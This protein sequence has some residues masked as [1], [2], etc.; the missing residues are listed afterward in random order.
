MRQLYFAVG[1]LFFAL[2]VIGAFLPVMPTT[3]FML[4]ALWAFAKSSPRFHDWLYRHPFFGP[5]LQQWQRHRVI[6]RTAKIMSI[7]MMSASL[8]YLVFFSGQPY[9][10]SAIV[11]AVMLYAAW[12]ILTKPSAIPEVADGS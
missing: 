10:V 1:W 6:P 7:S 11:G 3:P 2:G 8:G 5:P 4:L 12:F 9:Y